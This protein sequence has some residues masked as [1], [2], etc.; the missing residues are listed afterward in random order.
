LTD[1][2]NLPIHKLAAVLSEEMNR[3]DILKSL[4][5]KSR[6]NL[7]DRYLVPALDE[8]Y[9][10]MTIPDKPKS[11]NQKYKLTR[12]GVILRNK[13]IKAENNKSSQL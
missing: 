8:E 2:F 11:K 5:L 6:K 3:S 1:E 7:T 10:A 4:K 9:I 12:K 13:I